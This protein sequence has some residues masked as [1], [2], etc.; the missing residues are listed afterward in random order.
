MVSFSMPKLLLASL[1]VAIFIG[2]YIG[3]SQITPLPQTGYAP[4]L[5]EG[6]DTL[7]SLDEFVASIKNGQKNT[8]VGIYVPGILALPVGQ[9]PTDEAGYVTRKPD[10]LTQFN[11]AERYGTIGILAHNDLAGSDFSTI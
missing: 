8:V 5:L 11:L 10:Q 1:L 9:Q 3:M 2:S 4:Y 6:T 7:P